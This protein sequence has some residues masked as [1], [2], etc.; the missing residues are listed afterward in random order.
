MAAKS[1]KHKKITF[2]KERDFQRSNK[3]ENKKEE[4]SGSIAFLQPEI[5][6]IELMKSLLITVS[7]IPR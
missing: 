5:L 3:D 4:G 7:I 6:P 1:F 2:R